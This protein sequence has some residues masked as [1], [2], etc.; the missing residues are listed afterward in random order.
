[1]KSRLGAV[2]QISV[3]RLELHEAPVRG[4]NGAPVRGQNGAPVRGQ[5]GAPVRGQNGAPV[6]GQKSCASRVRVLLAAVLM[7]LCA[8]LQLTIKG[9]NGNGGALFEEVPANASGITWV[10]DNAMSNERYLPETLGPGCA[11]LDYDND[12]WMDVYLV[13]YGACDFFKPS[14]PIRN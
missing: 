9:Q 13:N 12:G 6:R 2:T 14:K 11:F 8:V 5:N 7:L 10:H 1:L 4:Q 3:R